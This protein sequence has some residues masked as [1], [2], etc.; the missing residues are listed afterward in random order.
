MSEEKLYKIS[1][2]PDNKKAISELT[3][4]YKEEGE[5]KYWITMDQGWRWG[6]WV[7]EVTAEELQELREDSENGVCEPDMY[8]GLEMDYLDD[9]VWLDFEGSKDV[10]AEMLDEF[11]TAFDEDSFDGVY[12]LGWE[13]TDC[14][15]FINTGLNINIEGENDE[16]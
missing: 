10:T 6:K 16:V 11:E 3:T 8:E 12:E 2:E 4:F 9:G 14:E 1:V 5:H 13:D 7:G 15:I